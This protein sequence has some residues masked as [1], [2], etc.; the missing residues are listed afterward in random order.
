MVS[1]KG[2][3]WVKH[4]LSVMFTLGRFLVFLLP[5]PPESEA[6]ALSDCHHEVSRVNLPRALL[7]G[8]E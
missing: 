7:H 1:R 2:A 6:G 4:A 8:G 5:V 3:I